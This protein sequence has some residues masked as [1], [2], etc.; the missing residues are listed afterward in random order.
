MVKDP[1][2]KVEE[3]PDEKA[4]KKIEKFGAK[5]NPKGTKYAIVKALKNHHC[6]INKVVYDFK[7]GVKY[8]ISKYAAFALERA[9]IVA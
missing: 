7:K 3:K 1:K 4:E 5:I 8:E 9:G 2:D 6:E